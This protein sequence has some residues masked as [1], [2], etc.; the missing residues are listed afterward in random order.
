[1][2]HRARLTDGEHDRATA[3]AHAL[4]QPAESRTIGDAVDRVGIVDEEK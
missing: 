1:V 4:D 3:H 2:S